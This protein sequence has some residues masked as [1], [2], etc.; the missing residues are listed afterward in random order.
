MIKFLDLQKLN[1]AYEARFAGVLAQTLKSGWFVH[2]KAHQ[3]FEREFAAYCGTKCCVGTGNGLDA[4]TLILRSCIALGKLQKGD[5]VIVAANTYIASIL[6]ILEA[7]LTP[8]LC[9]P[10][11]ATFNLSA[12]KAA[13]YIGPRTKA[14]MAVHL[15]GQ[16]CPME[17]LRTLADKYELLLVEDAAQAHGARTKSGLAGSLSDAAGFSFYPGK[18]LGALGDAGAVTTNDEELAQM[19][20][21]LRN[22]GSGKKYINDFRGVNS[23]L[24]ELQ[25]GF[26]SVKLGDLDAQNEQ[27]R[28]IAL[29]YLSDIDNPEITL[30][31][32][33]G[34]GDHV[35]HL[36][37]VRTK[38]RAA[39][40]NYLYENGVETMV[41]YPV[42]P[43]LQKALKPYDLGTFPLTQKIHDEVLSLPCHPLLEPQEIAHITD[44]LNRF[45]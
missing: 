4:L 29:R 19:V 43:H 23:R 44:L 3:S 35:F 45:S 27:R 25:A 38:R 39:L 15:Y 24:D 20:A 21:K 41:H 18:N 28:A 30:P 12:E 8:V 7:G 32:W 2:G 1:A 5:E 36:F 42:P 13:A 14:I 6:A 33:S 31:Y 9:E 40:Q 10:D 17:S 37:V 11:E 22:Y 26:L 16:L 34:T